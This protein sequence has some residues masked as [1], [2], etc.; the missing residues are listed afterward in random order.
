MVEIVLGLAAILLVTALI[1]RSMADATAPS[2][3]EYRPVKHEWASRID[4]E[5][6]ERIELDPDRRER[7]R[8]SRQLDEAYRPYIEAQRFKLGDAPPPPRIPSYGAAFAAAISSIPASSPACDTS[9]SA[10]VDC[11]SF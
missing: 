7:K 8:R 3:P 10:S 2:A 1:I 11:G 5:A 4:W 6:A 9:S